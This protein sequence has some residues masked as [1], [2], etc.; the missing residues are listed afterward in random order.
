MSAVD[1]RFYTVP[2]GHLTDGFHRR[3]L[4]GDIDLMSDLN[5]TSAGRDCVFE[6]RGDFLNVLWRNRNLDEVELDAFALFAL[7]NRSQHTSI[8]L[9][10]GQNFIAGF[11]IHP[12]QKC[13]E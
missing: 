7:T 5:Q 12:E 9:R 11:Q 4:T 2:P 6:C 13:L 8:I 3:D 10:G 1:D